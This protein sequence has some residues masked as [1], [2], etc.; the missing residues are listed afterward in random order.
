MCMQVPPGSEN[1]ALLSAA[2]SLAE[3]ADPVEQLTVISR[4][5]PMY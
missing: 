5:L 2:S 4:H 3:N 1:K